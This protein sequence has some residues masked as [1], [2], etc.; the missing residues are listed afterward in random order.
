MSQPTQGAF[1]ITSLNSV[2]DIAKKMPTEDAARRFLEQMIWGESRFCPHCGGFRSTALR[3]EKHRAGLYQCNDCRGQFSITTKTPLHST[4]LELRTWVEAIYI[5]LNSSKGVSSVVLA[6]MIGVTQKTAWKMGH[7]IR[8]MMYAAGDSKLLSGIVEVDEAYVGGAPKYKAGQTNPRGK[9]TKKQP[10]LVAIERGGEVR[11]AIMDGTSSA[12]IQPLVES[13]IDKASTLMTDSNHA[14]RSIGKTFAAHHYVKHGAKEFANPTTGAHINTA[15]AFS[16]FVERA[17]V[18]VYHR[19]TGYHTQ[20]Y[21]NDLTWRW[22]HREAHIGEKITKS[23]K[24]TPHIRWKPLPV[25]E[26]MRALLRKAPGREMRRS[27]NYG[28][29][30]PNAAEHA[31][32]FGG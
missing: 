11:A 28:I 15:E 5:V 25:I 14:Y 18:G 29:E 20:R 8:E 21:L 19:I 10:V 17:R 3:G 4:K 6:R 9:G 31:A 13:W 7:A 32:L 16:A 12:D 23:G 24:A 2:A 27:S 26:M 30:W 1:S 22:N